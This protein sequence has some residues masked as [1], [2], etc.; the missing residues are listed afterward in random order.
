MRIQEKMKIF[1]T[2]MHG[3]HVLEIPHLREKWGAQLWALDRMGPVCEHPDWFD[4]AAPL[5]AYGRM[6]WLKVT[7]VWPAT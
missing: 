4:Y 6:L 1:I 5:Q 7:V 3:D 2:H